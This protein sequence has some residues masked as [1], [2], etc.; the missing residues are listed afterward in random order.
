MVAFA[1]GFR[2]ILGAMPGRSW[3][4]RRFVTLAVLITLVPLGA[5]A[6]LAPPA[7]FGDGVCALAEARCT[8]PVLAV[9]GAF[10]AEL[11]PLIA[12]ATGPRDPRHRRS[13]PARRDHRRRAGRPRPAGHRASQCGGHHPSRARA[14]RRRRH[15]GVRR[16]R[17]APPHRRRDRSP[18]VVRP[19]RGPPCDRPGHA[20]GRTRR[21]AGGGPAGALHALS[22]RAARTDGLRGVRARGLRGRARRDRRPLRRSPAPMRSRRQRRVRMRRTHRGDGANECR[23]RGGRHGD[24]LGRARGRGP[25]RAVHRLP[26]RLRRRRRPPRLAG[27]PGAVL[28][29]LP[30]RRLQRG[31]RGRCVRRALGRGADHP[32]RCR[33]RAAGARELRVGAARHGGVRRPASLPGPAHARRPRVPPARAR[34]RRPG[35]SQPGV[36]ACGSPRGLGGG[37][38]SRRHAMRAIAGGAARR[39]GDD[40]R[41]HRSAG[42]RTPPC[43]ASRREAAG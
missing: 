15:R 28:R 31:R 40:R 24:G 16:G 13:R 8:R 37:A 39:P 23:P 43:A 20:R 32:R 3:T 30:A 41:M 27:V 26:R 7:G 18:D 14:L 29:L 11:E 6:A 10:P 5:H 36:A 21:G 33:T 19:R 1:G 35:G 9:L 42:G 2:A 25:W 34:R 22:R 12:R 38:W 4:S 17:L